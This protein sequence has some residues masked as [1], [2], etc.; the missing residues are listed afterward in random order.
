MEV[1]PLTVE[2]RRV[3]CSGPRPEYRA[4]PRPIGKVFITK[5]EQDQLN[6]VQRIVLGLKPRSRYSLLKIF[7]QDARPE[8]E[9]R[10]EG[11][12]DLSQREI[13]DIYERNG[14]SQTVEQRLKILLSDVF[15]RYQ[16]LW[17][18]KR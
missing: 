3:L 8:D 4:G 1:R 12:G 6:D 18:N 9:R 2:Q 5:H 11:V 7:S 14:S 17:L 10:V 13:V 15:D 16:R